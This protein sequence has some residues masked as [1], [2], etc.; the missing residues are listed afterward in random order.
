MDVVVC[1]EEEVEAEAAGW[2]EEEEEEGVAVGVEL[3][4]VCS[5]ARFLCLKVKTDEEDVGESSWG[6]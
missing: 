1:E 6:L 4:E 5:S 3:G 2:E